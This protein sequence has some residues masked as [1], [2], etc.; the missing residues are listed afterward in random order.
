MKVFILDVDVMTTGQFI[1]HKNGK[2]LHFLDQNDHYVV[3]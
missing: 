1:W 3:L 2:L